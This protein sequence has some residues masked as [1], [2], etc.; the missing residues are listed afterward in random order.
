MGRKP[1][2][3]FEIKVSVVENYLEYVKGTELLT[4]WL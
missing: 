2:V 3:L 1:K 4:T